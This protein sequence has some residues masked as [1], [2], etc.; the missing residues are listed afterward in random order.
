MFFEQIDQI[1]TIAQRT[2]CGVFVVPPTF[3]PAELPLPHPL[4]LRPDP[5]KK[6]EI[7][8]V[9]QLRDFL[10]LTH[11]RST[12]ERFFLVTP[13]HALNLAAQ[14]AFLKTFEEPKSHYHFLLFTDQPQALLPTIL[15]RAQIFYLQTSGQL[16]QAPSADSKILALAKQ[17]IAASPEQ[18]PALATTLAKVKTQPRQ[19]ALNVTSAAIELLYKSYF[20]TQNPKFLAKLDG[21]LRLHGHLKRGGHIKLHLVAD[22]C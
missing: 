15:S 17:L 1:P 21:F 5:N 14:N 8:T 3:D 4:I 6:T 7:I 10:E 9:E 22:L 19:H 18:L 20:K 2:S 13:A 12:S 16:D 11:T